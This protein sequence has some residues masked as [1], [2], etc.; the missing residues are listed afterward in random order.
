MRNN[1]YN[2]GYSVNGKNYLYPQYFSGQP[3]YRVATEDSY[4]EFSRA[5]GRNT[6]AR[7]IKPEDVPRGGLF[8]PFRKLLSSPN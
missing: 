6:S 1:P 2:A 7:V 5:W 4:A 8:A 3:G